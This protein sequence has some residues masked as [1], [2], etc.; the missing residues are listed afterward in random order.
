MAGSRTLLLGL[1]L[2]LLPLTGSVFAAD[3]GG[4]PPDPGLIPVSVRPNGA[5]NERQLAELAA[6]IGQRLGTQSA[7]PVEVTRPFAPVTRLRVLATL[8]KLGIVGDGEIAPASAPPARMPPDAGSVPAWGVPYVAAAVDQGW[9]TTDRPIS[10]REVAT[11]TF[12]KSLVDRMVDG[13]APE[14]PAPKQDRPPVTGP[15]D[16][17]PSSGNTG[18]NYTGLVV[19]ARGLDVQRAMGPRIVDEDGGVIY[20]D[21]RHVPDKAFLEDHGMAAYTSD[22]A[23]APRSGSHPLVV[24]AAGVTGPGHDDLVV[25]R[26]TARQIR[27]A[28][29]HGGFLSRWAVSILLGAR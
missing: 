26:D 1:T 23:A 4:S 2:T 18:D 9:W 16:G 10:A 12:V 25:S 29:E 11:W 27:E 24:T 14:S 17:S 6:R 15:A 21:P 20:P 8:V 19:D 5:V 22:V 3:A 28:G 7:H 13:T